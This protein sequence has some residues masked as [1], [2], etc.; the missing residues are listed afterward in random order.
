MCQ[1]KTVYVQL[2]SVQ[3]ALFFATRGRRQDPRVLDRVSL[4]LIGSHHTLRGSKRPPLQLNV[5]N[6]GMLFHRL[7]GL[8]L[9]WKRAF[10]EKGLATQ[11]DVSRRRSKTGIRSP[12]ACHTIRR[13]NHSQHDPHPQQFTVVVFPKQTHVRLVRSALGGSA[14][15][16]RT[17]H[18][19][20][21]QLSNC[22]KSASSMSRS[23]IVRFLNMQRYLARF[24]A[25][26]ICK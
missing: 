10:S 15:A 26:S 24:L 21:R 6:R 11:D 1:K 8:N 3:V 23:S 19:G 20:I 14:C 16:P 9:A 18:Q 25:C 2:L 12:P 7:L 17:L 5:P 22:W 4:M 13:Y